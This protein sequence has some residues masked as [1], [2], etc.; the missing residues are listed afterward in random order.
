MKKYT[1]TEKILKLYDMNIKQNEINIINN[2]LEQ[3]DDNDIE[4]IN[5]VCEINFKIGFRSAAEILK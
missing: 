3:F 4:L 2:L 1:T 5:K